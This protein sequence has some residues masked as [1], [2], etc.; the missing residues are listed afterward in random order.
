MHISNKHTS[1]QVT[2][3]R[4]C[5]YLHHKQAVLHQREYSYILTV[6]SKTLWRQASIETEPEG[7][8]SY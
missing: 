8:N 3:L 1:K 5:M 7:L 2:V 6:R 4:P